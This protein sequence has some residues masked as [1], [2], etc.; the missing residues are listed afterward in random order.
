M[1]V[2]TEFFV[3]SS[4]VICWWWESR[5]IR[6]VP[7]HWPVW[8]H[9]TEVVWEFGSHRGAT[10]L[11]RVELSGGLLRSTVETWEARAGRWMGINWTLYII[12]CQWPS[13][14]LCWGLRKR[15]GSIAQYSSTFFP[16][17]RHNMAGLI[18]FSQ[19]WSSAHHLLWDNHICMPLWIIPLLY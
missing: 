16:L 9:T 13:L 4:K 1:S 10:H 7:S 14:S 12:L 8:Y 11:A 17:D 15:Q 18:N 2:K 6:E 19:R 3:R 5:G